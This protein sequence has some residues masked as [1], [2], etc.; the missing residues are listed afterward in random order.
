MAAIHYPHLYAQD[1]PWNDTDYKPAGN[2]LWKIPTMLT[3][4]ECMMLSY[5]TEHVYEG[6]GAIV[7]LGCFLGGSSA[8]LANGLASNPNAGSYK[9]QSFDLFKL[10]A[11]ERDH[12]FPARKLELPKDDDTFEMFNAHIAPFKNYIRAHRGNILDYQWDGGPI[13]ILFVDLMKSSNLYD[14]V[15]ETFLPHLIPN[16]SIMILQDF[17]FGKTGAWHMNL[18]EKLSKKFTFFGQTEINSVVYKCIAPISPEDIES[19]KWENIPYNERILNLAKNASRWQ[20]PAHQQIILTVLENM[21]SEKSQWNSGDT[22]G[23]NYNTLSRVG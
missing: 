4:E 21:L 5:L 20:K 13:E 9:V 2:G 17:M 10:A 14:Y 12:F 3:A 23:Q 6:N 7:D 19:C 1:R 16:Q 18:M 8:F 11:F 15:I 22:M